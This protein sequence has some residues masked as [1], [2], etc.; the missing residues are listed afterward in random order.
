MS[1]KKGNGFDT[2]KDKNTDKPYYAHDEWA[3]RVNQRL[4]A[5]NSRAAEREAAMKQ[6]EL[7]K[8]AL[9]LQKAKMDM[10]KAKMK[11]AQQIAQAQI[12]AQKHS[13][14]IELQKAK[15]ELQHAQILKTEL[16]QVNRGQ[17]SKLS[18]ST[19]LK[20]SGKSS[21]KSAP[22]KA[23]PRSSGSSRKK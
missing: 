8:E 22:R 11:Q 23:T 20:G 12:A 4:E 18:S 14:M 6:M 5:R 10:E 17:K 21:A 19:K 3:I 16:Q 13:Q 1:E 2:P 9:K 15:L 7:Q